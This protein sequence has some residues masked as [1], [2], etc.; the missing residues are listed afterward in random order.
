MFN[1]K[2]DGRSLYGYTNHQA[3]EVLRNTGKIVKLRL[4]R[5]LRGSKYEQLQQAISNPDLPIPYYPQSTPGATV[6][7]IFDQSTD[8]NASGHTFSSAVS[9]IS[10]KDN[11]KLNGQSSDDLIK[12]WEKIMG[13]NYDIVVSFLYKF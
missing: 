4:A 13:Q 10:I 7:Q 2:V 8:P 1:W 3:V 11:T 6:I 5:Y 12:K 9:E